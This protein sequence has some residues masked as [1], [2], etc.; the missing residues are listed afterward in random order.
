MRN[1]VVNLEDGRSFVV[2][3]RTKTKS[4]E[5]YLDVTF[6]YDSKKE[7]YYISY[8]D[9]RKEYLSGLSFNHNRKYINKKEDKYGKC[10]YYTFDSTDSE[11]LISIDNDYDP[12]VYI[13]VGYWGDGDQKYV[14]FEIPNGARIAYFITHKT[15]TYGSLFKNSTEE[16]SVPVLSAVEFD[17]IYGDDTNRYASAGKACNYVYTSF[18][19]IY[20]DEIRSGSSLYLTECKAYALISE[21]DDLPS[22]T[23]RKYSYTSSP[24]YEYCIYPSVENVLDEND[25]LIKTYDFVFDWAW[26]DMSKETE[27]TIINS[28]RLC[29]NNK[30]DERISYNNKYCKKNTYTSTAVYM[31]KVTQLKTETV[32]DEICDYRTIYSVDTKTCGNSYG[33]EIPSNITG[34]T[35]SRRY[36]YEYNS[37]DKPT[38]ITETIEGEITGITTNTYYNDKYC[39]LQGTVYENGSGNT[40]YDKSYYVNTYG[41]VIDETFTDCNDAQDL[42]KKLCYG[43]DGN[44]NVSYIEYY[45]PSGGLY[46]CDYEYTNNMRTREYAV[47][48]GNVIAEKIT[49][50]ESGTNRIVSTT[51][52]VGNTEEY[53]YGLFGRLY[54]QTHPDGFEITNDYNYDSNCYTTVAEDG[55]KTKTIVYNGAVSKVIEN[56]RSILAIADIDEYGHTVKSTDAEGNVI[57][58]EYDQF[59]R[60]RHITYPN[61][62]NKPSISSVYYY[63]VFLDGDTKCSIVLTLN[64]ENKLSCNYYDTKGRLVKTAV[65]ANPGELLDDCNLEYITSMPSYVELVV[66]STIEYNDLDQAVKVTDGE[67]RETRY[68]YDVLG[69][70]LSVSQGTGVSELHVEY[71]Y[72]AFGNVTRMSQGKT[73]PHVTDYEYDYAGRLIKTTDPMGFTEEKTYDKAGN[74]IRFKDKN[75]DITT[76]TYDERNRLASTSKRGKSISYTYDSV[77]NMLTSTDESGII[78][79]EYN[80]DRTLKKKIMPDNKTISYTEYDGNKR[81]TSMTDFFGNVT[82]YT[83]DAHGNIESICEKYNGSTSYKTTSYTYNQDNTLSK[84]S[85]PNNMTVQYTY[86][87]AGRV[88]RLKNDAPYVTSHS[89]HLYEYDNSNNIIKSTETMFGHDTLITTYTYDSVNRLKQEN[90]SEWWMYT[91]DEYNNILSAVGE[92]DIFYTYDAN[93]RLIKMEDLWSYGETADGELLDD[94]QTNFTYDNN[95][96]LLSASKNSAPNC[97]GYTSNQKNYTYNVWG[98]LTDFSDSLGGSAE[99]TYYS[100]GLRSSRRVGINTFKYYY[101]GDKIINETKNGSNFATNIYGVDGPISRQYGGFEHY[102]YKNVHGDVIFAFTSNHWRSSEYS[103]SAFGEENMNYDYF[104]GN[105][106]PLRYSGEYFD[107]ESGMTY[108]RA[109]YYDPN[110]RRFISEDPAEDGLNWYVYCENNPVNAWDPSGQNTIREFKKVK[111]KYSADIAFQAYDYSNL[112]I[113]MANNYAYKHGLDSAWNNEADAYRHFMWNAMMTRHIGYYEAKFISNIHEYESMSDDGWIDNTL[114]ISPE[115]SVWFYGSMNQ[116]ILMD[117]WNNQVGRELANN[118]CYSDMNGDQLFRIALEN[119]W[120]ITDANNVFQFLGIQDCISDQKQYIVDVAWNTETNN[121]IVYKDGKPSV[122]L[123]IGV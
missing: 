118:A 93:N 70:V 35:I 65:I 51:D 41:D 97:Y 98:Q 106:N 112:S 77:G 79:Y 56:D 105:P 3:E 62:N 83:Y 55:Y 4:G 58:I 42:I 40:I 116:E 123:K 67:G 61:I 22:G 94:W 39:S 75:G 11:K 44:H 49:A 60:Q 96:K 85:I 63:D 102:Y 6:N 43:Y 108:L 90:G 78:R 82:A 89:E 111:E 91:Y 36:D 24:V 104:S 110:Q 10:I 115:N 74:I 109:R 122:E 72:D 68:T 87:Y 38:K 80:S 5:K 23:T 100:D 28:N 73:N 18:E 107:T 50:Y 119:N 9:E 32:A 17:D 64:P 81:L 12:N 46:G 117:L 71:T 25:Q 47:Q 54:S 103:Y 30:F 31:G 26:C 88:T 14:T 113:R 37:F 29:E 114:R 34:E 76:N 33:T 59:G 48:N 95:G 8:L 21:V 20:L 99:Y 92:G 7:V 19:S 66:T 2:D 101:D 57:N 120:L 1:G 121:I 84:I 86:D 53:C 27:T 13:D 69:N 15:L 45:T 52:G 16:I